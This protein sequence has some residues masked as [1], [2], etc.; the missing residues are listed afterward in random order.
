MG[1]ACVTGASS[2]I[3]REF[4]RILCNMGYDLILVGRNM[5]KL[6]DTKTKL[7]QYNPDSSIKC[8]SCDFCSEEAV[9]KLGKTEVI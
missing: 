2:G 5:T 6:Q 7:L 1:I 4:A 8:I 9:I 3:G